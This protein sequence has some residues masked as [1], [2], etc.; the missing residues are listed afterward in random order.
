M[1]E[2]AGQR[3]LTQSSNVMG[4]HKKKGDQENSSWY[5]HFSEK[6]ARGKETIK[7]QGREENKGK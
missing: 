7:K 1:A 3:V 6:T 2:N 4:S 5:S